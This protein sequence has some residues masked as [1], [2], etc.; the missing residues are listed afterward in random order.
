MAQSNQEFSQEFTMNI[1]EIFKDKALKILA[2]LYAQS[3]YKGSLYTPLKDLDW[4][5]YADIFWE[6]TRKSTLDIQKSSL[7]TL[8]KYPEDAF[9]RASELIQNKKVEDRIF[10]FLIF[11]EL[12]SEV[13]MALL[14]EYYHKEK[15]DKKVREI[16]KERIGKQLYGQD[17]ALEKV[18]GYFCQRTRH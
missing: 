18:F 9:S 17:V 12:N 6:F 7:F 1:K 15:D 14:H 16:I 2:L 11:I 10:A 13:S 3:I 4:F 8:V 5:P